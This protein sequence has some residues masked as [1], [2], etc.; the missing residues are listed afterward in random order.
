MIKMANCKSYQK[1]THLEKVEMIGKITH[2]L[3]NWET[4]F[5]VVEATINAA[6]LAGIFHDVKINPPHEK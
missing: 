4:G 3:Q 1:L 6:T 5:E 2:L